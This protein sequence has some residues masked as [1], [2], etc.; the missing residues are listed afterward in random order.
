MT[1]TPIREPSLEALRSAP[2]SFRYGSNRRKILVDSY[3][4][5]AVLAV[6]GAANDANKAKLERMISASFDSFER[7]VAFAF[8][9]C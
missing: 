9:A 5:S 1:F 7:V 4:A 3:T 8:K 2:V 6:Y